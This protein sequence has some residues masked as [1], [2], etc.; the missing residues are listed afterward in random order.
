MLGAW[1][2]AILAIVAAGNLGWRAFVKAVR[3]IIREELSR[4]WKDQDDI[5]Q[6]LTA[7]ELTLQFVREQLDRLERMMLTHVRGDDEAA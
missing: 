6:R 2:G 1:A 7:L 5:E 4:V 3:G